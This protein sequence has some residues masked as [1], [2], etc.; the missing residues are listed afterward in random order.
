LRPITKPDIIGARI[1]DVHSA[2]N[3]LDGFDCTFTYFTVDRGIA[4]AMPSPG[5]R[6][7]TT[8][9]PPVARRLP[10]TYVWESY[11]IEGCWPSMRFIPEPS[12]TID[13]IK[14]LKQRTIAGVHCLKMDKEL[15]FYKPDDAVLLFD[16]GSQAYCITGAPHGTGATGLHY[17]TDPGQLL[18]MDDLVDFFDVPIE[19][20]KPQ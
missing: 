8:E 20:C 10:D 17:I 3:V 14:R 19:D 12:T 4:F 1:T 16:D 2:S 9:V 13:I 7:Q 11:K 5:Y 6:W 18:K 15:G